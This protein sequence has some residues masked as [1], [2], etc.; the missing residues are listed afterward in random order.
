M[1]LIEIIKCG[2][3]KKIISI[4]DE[5]IRVVGDKIQYFNRFKTKPL[6]SDYFDGL[7]TSVYD[8]DI[9]RLNQ[10]GSSLVSINDSGHHV[11]IV[12]IENPNMGKWMGEYRDIKLQK[13]LS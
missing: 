8:D 5:T 9:R 10:T 11:F 4:S 1:K 3:N 12:D 13:L 2:D 7:W 6:T